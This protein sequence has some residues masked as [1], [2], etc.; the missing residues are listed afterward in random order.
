MDGSSGDDGTLENGWVPLMRIPDPGDASWLH[1]YQATATTD[2]QF[3]TGPSSSVPR[4]GWPGRTDAW[5]ISRQA[6]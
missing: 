1:S 3:T 2:R 6:A 5:A 4:G